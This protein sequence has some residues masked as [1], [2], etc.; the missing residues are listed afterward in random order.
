MEEAIT[1]TPETIMIHPLTLNEGRDYLLRVHQVNGQNPVYLPVRFMSY[2]PCPALVVI[3]DGN[4]QQ[5]RVPRDELFI[6]E[7]AILG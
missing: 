4:G 1:K 2:H 7:I 3:G 5:W 6:P